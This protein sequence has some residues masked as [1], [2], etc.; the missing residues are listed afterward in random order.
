MLSA[1]LDQR[2]DEDSVDS[3]VTC[4]V[5]ESLPRRVL[6]G[7]IGDDVEDGLQGAAGLDFVRGARRRFDGGGKHDHYPTD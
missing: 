1:D 7:L 5:G 6:V 3:G 4:E 2:P